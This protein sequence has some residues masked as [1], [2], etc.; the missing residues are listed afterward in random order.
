MI[1]DA[2]YYYNDFDISEGTHVLE[3]CLKDHDSHIDEYNAASE[4]VLT[5]YTVF[6]EGLVSTYNKLLENLVAGEN[7]HNL[8]HK[9]N[10]KTNTYR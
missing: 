6:N 5:R 8:S 10:W 2:G 9:Y 4:E 3:A 7:K 1:Q